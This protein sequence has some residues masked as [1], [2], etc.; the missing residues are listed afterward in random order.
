MR[1]LVGAVDGFEGLRWAFR[2]KLFDR[3]T[4]PN[5]VSITYDGRFR[6]GRG[7]YTFDFVR[8]RNGWRIE[9]VLRIK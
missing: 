8:T 4:G 6:V 7:R 1:R 3:P 5:R 2:L 9:R